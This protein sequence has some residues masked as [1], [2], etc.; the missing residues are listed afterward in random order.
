MAAQNISYCSCSKKKLRSSMQS[1]AVSRTFQSNICQNLW[2]LDVVRLSRFH[3]SIKLQITPL[4][5]RADVSTVFNIPASTL[6][7]VLCWK[8]EIERRLNGRQRRVRASARVHKIKIRKKYWRKFILMYFSLFTLFRF[9][10]VVSL[11][12]FTDC[13]YNL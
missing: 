3:D 5:F 8:Y 13:C 6:G 2:R 11:F 9:Q 10:C 7:R 12:K 4:F 1:L